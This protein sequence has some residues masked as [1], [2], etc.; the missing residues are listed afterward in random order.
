VYFPMGNEATGFMVIFSLIAAVVGAASCLSG[1]HHLRVWT[2]HSLASSTASSMT[3][4]ALTLLAMGYIHNNY[5]FTSYE[6]IRI[7]ISDSSMK[8]GRAN[9]F[10]SSK[11]HVGMQRDPYGRSKQSWYVILLCY[12]VHTVTNFLITLILLW[13]FVSLRFGNFAFVCG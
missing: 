5:K 9:Y 10:S 1:L 13:R 6:S 12:H 11:L 4:W 7:M 2:A 8:C 3:A